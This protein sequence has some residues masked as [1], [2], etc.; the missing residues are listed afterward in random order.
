MKNATLWLRVSS[1]VSVLFAAGHAMGGRQDWSPPG[2]TPVLAAMRST[3]FDA[4]G[5]SRTYL[6]F[7]RGFGHSLTVT[8]LLQAVVL[9]QLGNI[10]RSNPALVRPI[11]A[12][13]AIA[14]AV[15]AMIAC[16]FLVPHPVVFSVVLIVLLAL[17]YVAAR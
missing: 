14:T 16:V 3:S 15:S 13:F 10:A 17:A 1:V 7:Y 12:S 11:V 8:L 5:F 4:F 9:W 6:D 2:E